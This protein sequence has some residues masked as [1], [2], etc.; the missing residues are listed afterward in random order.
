[1]EIE[2]KRRLCD[3]KLLER[4]IARRPPW[5][6]AAWREL[7]GM[8]NQE[9]QRLPAR[10][11]APFVLCCLQG[12]SKTEAAQALGWKQ[13]TVSGRLARAR[14]LLRRRLARPYLEAW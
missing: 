11:R 7:R 13:G 6:E 12:R 4:F 14:K 10:L 3:R 1:M 5:S 8:L 2:A 9:M